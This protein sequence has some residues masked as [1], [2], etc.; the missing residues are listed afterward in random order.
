MRRRFLSTIIHHFDRQTLARL[1]ICGSFAIT[2]CVSSPTNQVSLEPPV[3][4]RTTPSV[5]PVSQDI[6][7][8]E[9]GSAREFGEVE[10]AVQREIVTP[11][12]CAIAL[13]AATVGQLGLP[14]ETVPATE[15]EPPAPIP[16]GLSLGD[17]EAMALQHNPTIQQSSSSVHKGTGYRA[18]VGVRPNPTVG[19]S[20]QQLADRGTD[21]H[22]VF[23][24]QEFVTGGKLAWN[25]TVLNA[26]VQAQLWDVETR[27]QMVLTDVRR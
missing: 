3:A 19:F 1:S 24:E 23:V 25:Q 7:T 16:N 2:G 5:T 21:Q 27:R 11:Q 8:K 13:T 4:V 17:L 10:V 9:P 22:S 15:I 12:K 26:G 14:A 6:Q 20:A 18:Q